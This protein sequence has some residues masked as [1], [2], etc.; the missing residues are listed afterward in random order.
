[1]NIAFADNLDKGHQKMSYSVYAGGIHALDAKMDLDITKKNYFNMELFAKTYGL[2]GRLA[3]WFGTFET[4]GWLD[5]N[6][7]VAKPKIHKSSTTWKDELEVKTYEYN[8]DGSFKKYSIKDNKND[9]RPRKIDSKLTDQTTDIISASLEEMMR[10]SA[11]NKCEGESE[12]FDGKRRYRLIF[13]H[14]REVDLKKSKYN[15]FEGKAIE[16]SVRVEP[17]GGRWDKKPRGWFAIQEQ[18]KKKGSMPTIWFGSL[19]NNE[20]AI[21]VKVRVKTDYGTFFL[22]LT[23]YEGNSLQIA[24]EE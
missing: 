4:N 13:D 9:G 8:K 14:K 6:K 5:I 2:L 16:C 20:P 7:G 12:V 18:G 23:E 24:L 21:P 1:M 17:A 11:S 22:H 15:I 10:V 3:P 19:D